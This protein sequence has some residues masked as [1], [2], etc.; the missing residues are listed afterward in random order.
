MGISILAGRDFRPQ[1]DAAAPKVAIVN[2]TA[3]RTWFGAANPI[4]ERLALGADAKAADIEIVGVVK[5]ARYAGLNQQGPNGPN[6]LYIPAAQDTPVTQGG[7]DR[8]TFEVRTTANPLALADRVC[9]TVRDTDARVPV[10]NI[11]T[12]AVQVE[13]TI[14][15][16]R[17]M[18]TISTFFGALALLL[19]A[20]GLY[21][22]MAYAVAR[23]T[24]EIGIRMALGAKRSTVQW[25]VL[26]DTFLLVV[27]G[28]AIGIPAALSL[29]RFAKSL[30]FGVEAN[31]PLTIACASLLM[32]LIA[33]A[34]GYLPAR[35][36]S[37]VD[38]MIAL[39]YE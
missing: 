28:I 32:L 11:R 5:D 3:A 17:L 6:V 30:L 13:S 27:I 8:G 37:R 36:A 2:Q 20:I 15:K 19:A 34:A 14:V 22:I 12:M 25:M 33:V 9:H 23:R 1:D 21:G 24:T 26:R 35:R 7:I 18:A 16:E 31:D 4:G 29:T 38:P 39:R 10:S